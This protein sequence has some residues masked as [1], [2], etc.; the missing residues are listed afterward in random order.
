[1]KAQRHQP[2]GRVSL[3]LPPLDVVDELSDDEV[4]AVL[5][6]LSAMLV[7]LS[8]R[9]AAGLRR[10]DP[11]E[12]DLL[13]VDETAKLTRRSTSWLNHHGHELPGFRQPHGKGGRKF[14][15]RR[16]LMSWITDGE[17]AC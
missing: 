10:V 8:A 9:Q 12:D 1:M 6:H 13:D 5:T 7:R 15:S 11:V 16:A 17:G 4:P 3:V 14:S 2:G